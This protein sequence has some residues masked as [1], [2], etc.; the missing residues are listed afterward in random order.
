MVKFHR[1]TQLRRVKEI[2]VRAVEAGL[3][4]HWISLNIKKDKLLPQKIAIF[5]PLDGYYN[6]KFCHMQTVLPLIVVR[7]QMKDYARRR[8]RQNYV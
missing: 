8:D 5:H 1:D 4:K 2:I 6:F 3:Y 7:S